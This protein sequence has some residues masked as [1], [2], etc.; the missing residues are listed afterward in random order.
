[1]ATFTRRPLPRKGN[2]ETVPLAGYWLTY[3][4]WRLL[5]Y[6]FYCT[7]GLYLG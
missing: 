3:Y 4:I 2:R 5:C 7:D 6:Y 1:M